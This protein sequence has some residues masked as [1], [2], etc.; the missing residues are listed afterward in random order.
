MKLTELFSEVGEPFSYYPGFVTKFSISTNASVLLCFIGWKTF[1]DELDGWKSFSTDSIT[2]STGLSVKEQATAR[3]QLV[4]AGLIEEY[5][6]RLEHVLKF[7]ILA[8]EL[9]GEWPNAE[10]AYAQTPFRRMAKRPFGVSSKEQ[11][12]DNKGKEEGAVA[13]SVVAN[14]PKGA[15]LSLNRKFSDEWCKAYEEK[16]GGKYA[17]QGGRDGKAVASLMKFGTPEELIALAKKAWGQTDPQKFW[18]CINHSSTISK[19]LNGLPSI[20]VEL[21]R[22]KTVNRGQFCH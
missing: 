19:F 14:E 1:K 17:F 22:A 5:Y 8:K 12:G 4:A 7:K 9:T 2:K 3:K 6:A 20:R 21:S 18:N 16:F 10:S 15:T 13:P 11:E